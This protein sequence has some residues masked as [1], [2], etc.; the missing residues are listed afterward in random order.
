MPKV[1][2]GQISLREVYQF[3]KKNTKTCVDYKT[4]KAILDL[5]GTKMNEYLLEGRDV[6]FF[7]GMSKIGFRKRYQTTYVDYKASKEAKRVIRRS[8]SKSG[9]FTAYLYWPRTKTKINS[10]FWKFVGSRKLKRA[11]VPLMQEL[12]GHTR[13][14]ERAKMLNKYAA[15]VYKNR[16]LKIRT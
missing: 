4:H 14:V 12:R 6:D 7:A 11:V 10:K 1:N 8:N 15:L 5:Y 16:V 13:Y 9:N 3:Y 2:K